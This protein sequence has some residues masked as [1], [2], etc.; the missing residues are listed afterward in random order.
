MAHLKEIIKMKPST[1][2]REFR[3]NENGGNQIN[4]EARGHSVYSG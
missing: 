4:G 1:R 2:H 3:A